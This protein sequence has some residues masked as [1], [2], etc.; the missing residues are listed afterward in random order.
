MQ[1]RAQAEVL[2]QAAREKL[3]ALK[4]GDFE[5][6]DE[7]LEAFARDFEQVRLSGVAGIV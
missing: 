1:V 6:T 5:E 3:A 4:E 7:E 2:T